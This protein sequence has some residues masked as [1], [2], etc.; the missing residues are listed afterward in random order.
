MRGARRGGDIPSR[1]ITLVGEPIVGQCRDDGVVA[2][3][4][5]GLPGGG[6]VPREPECGEVGELTPGDVGVG[7]IVE[8][9]DVHQG[10]PPARTGEHPRQHRGA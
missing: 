5:F 6:T 7:A 3:R 10:L 8:V 9:L 1:A 2:L 4:V